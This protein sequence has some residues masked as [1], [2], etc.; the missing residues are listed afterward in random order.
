M[1][2]QGRGC[3]HC[4]PGVGAGR[5]ALGVAGPLYRGGEWLGELNDPL[6]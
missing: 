1:T 2:D 3:F 5:P 4:A 6:A